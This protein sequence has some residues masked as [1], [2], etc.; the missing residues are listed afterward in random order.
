LRIIDP[1]DTLDTKAILA[2][3]SALVSSRFHGLVSALSAGVP[4]LACGWSHKYAELMA[5]YGAGKHIAD[6]DRPE[7]WGPLLE[8]FARDAQDEGFR[9]SLAQA[10]RTQKA[11]AATAWDQIG[12]TIT[13]G[14]G[15]AT[16]TQG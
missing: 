5:D 9:D 14:T 2:A 16:V 1:A 6:L 7:S 4:S 3:A 10:S 12:Q 13:A 8:A 11:R 15:V